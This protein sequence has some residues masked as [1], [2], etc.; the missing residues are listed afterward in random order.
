MGTHGDNCPAV[1]ANETLYQLSYT[2]VISKPEISTPVAVFH[3]AK[4]GF[5]FFGSNRHRWRGSIAIIARAMRKNDCSGR[6]RV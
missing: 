1:I 6:F 5:A 3:Q 4:T 2:P